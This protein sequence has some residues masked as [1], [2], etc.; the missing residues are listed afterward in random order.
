MKK[1]EKSDDGGS[2]NKR[3]QT[4]YIIR[5]QRIMQRTLN[6][7][8]FRDDSVLRNCNKRGVGSQRMKI[9]DPTD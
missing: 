8:T 9:V 1:P 4:Y 2:R 7:S 3:F 6:H 5:K